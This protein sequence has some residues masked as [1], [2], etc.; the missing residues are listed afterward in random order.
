MAEQGIGDLVKSISDDVKSL[1][2]D[3]IELVK[4]ELVPSAKKAGI[5]AGMFGGAAYF[6]ICAASLLYF[7]AAYGLSAGT[8]LPLWAGF[9]IVG[10][11]LLLVAGILALIGLKQVKQVKAP[12]KAVA[13]VNH[14]VNELKSTVQRATAAASA[15]QIEGTVVKDNRSLTLR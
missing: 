1:V 14:T 8:G 9:L 4:S 5:G 6:A 15:P 2:R 13:N 7:A 10:V 3:E 11:V 12:E